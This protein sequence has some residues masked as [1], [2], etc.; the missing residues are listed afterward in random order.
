[1]A[2]EFDVIVIG[3]GSA[4]ENVAGRTVPGGLSTAIIEREL[5]GGECTYWACMPSKALLRPSEVLAAIDRVP[6]TK[7]PAGYHL[8]VAKALHSRNSLSSNWDDKGQVQWVES[9][10]ATLIRGQGRLVGPRQVEVEAKDGQRSVLTAR[11]AVVVATG[12]TAAVPPIEGLAEAQPWT[13]REATTSSEVPQRL[14]VLGGG[15]VGV[16]MAQAWKSLGAKEV[17]IIEMAPRLL[18]NEEPFAGELVEKALQSQG[19][20]VLTSVRAQSVSR[21]GGAVTL[22]L[23]DGRQFQADELLAAT[24]RRPATR[25]LGMETVGLEPGAYIA[26]DDHLQATKNDEGWLYAIGD[27]NGRA[28][29]THQGKYQ[30]RIAGDHILGKDVTAWADNGAVPRVVFGDPQVAAVG[31]TEQQ[32]K[33]QGATVQVVEVPFGSVAATALMGQGIEG[34][35]KLVIDERERTIVGATFVGPGAGELVH[36]ATIAVVGKVTLDTLWH[37]VPSFPTLSELW[38]RLLETYGL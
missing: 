17:T 34:R 33:D 4:G 13:S 30:A 8:D 16:E 37:A 32:A 2:E 29:L 36:A 27:V 31:L 7:V 20:E 9:V 1:M 35:A 12:S 38:L 3:G 24:G 25:D 21:A 26:V 19:I 23:A 14:I 15:A 28:L 11:K 18:P 10:G 6:A 5:V 22:T